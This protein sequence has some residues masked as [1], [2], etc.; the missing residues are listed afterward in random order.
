MGADVRLSA[1][2][3]RA[4][5]PRLPA[6][7]ATV[8]D[9]LLDSRRPHGPS[10]T[11][12]SHA[13]RSFAPAWPTASRRRPN[14]S[15]AVARR[16]ISPEQPD[17]EGSTW[18]K[19]LFARDGNL[20]AHATQADVAGWLLRWRA[21][22]DAPAA[23]DL[24]PGSR[25]RAVDAELRGHGEGHT[26][27]HVAAYHAHGD[28]VDAALATRR[29]G[30]CHRQDVGHAAVALGPDRVEQAAPNLK[31]L[32]PRRRAAGCCRQRA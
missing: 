16:S 26:G 5:R 1:W 15:P 24:L 7:S 13:A 11:R 30:G 4:A 2:L 29:S 18:C 14:T 31:R 10:G 25:H 23:V 19:D 3:P 6:C 32:L 21:R 20:T 22:T 12:R 28:V 9:V 27:L 8:I 17:W